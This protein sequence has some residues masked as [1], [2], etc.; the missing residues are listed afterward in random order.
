MWEEV[1]ATNPPCHLP[2]EKTV[3]NSVLIEIA[4]VSADTRSG[5][6]IM[7][8]KSYKSFLLNKDSGSRMSFEST[9]STLAR[10]FSANT[11]IAC[12]CVSQPA[13]VQIYSITTIPTC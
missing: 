3:N 9:V 4:G 1:V 8:N 13:C 6:F 7:R 12:L 11:I 2:E 10:K 5:D